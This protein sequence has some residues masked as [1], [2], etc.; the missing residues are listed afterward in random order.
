MNFKILFTTDFERE[1][2]RLNRKYPSLRSDFAHFLESLQQNP[3]QGTFLG[4]DCYKVRMAI[5]SKNQGKSGGVRVLTCVKIID[6]VIFLFGIYDKSDL[7]ALP[8]KEIKKRLRDL[9]R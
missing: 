5:S 1:L 4:K 6:E 9:E 3:M 8:D 2:K 7:V